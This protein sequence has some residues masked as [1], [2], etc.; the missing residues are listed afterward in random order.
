MHNA[1]HGAFALEFDAAENQQYKVDVIDF[2]GRV[3]MTRSGA[4]AR[5]PN[6]INYNFENLAAGIYFVR[7]DLEDQTRLLR[8]VFE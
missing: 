3:I 4:T 8:V 6:K 7:I 2:T 1:T 5:G